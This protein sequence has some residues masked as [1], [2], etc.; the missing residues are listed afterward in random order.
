MIG[1]LS[2]A[3][4]LFSGVLLAE[5]AAAPQPAVDH[6]AGG[7]TA[8]PR[9]TADAHATGADGKSTGDSWRYKQHNGRWWYWLPANRWVVWNGAKW[10]DYNPATTSAPS[11]VQARRSYSPSTSGESKFLG[12][13]RYDRFGNPQYPYSRRRTG[14]KQLGP[15]PAMGGVRSLPGWGGER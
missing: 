1:T 8:D 9:A 2:F 5:P 13:K 7:A 3:G 4:L 6:G 10:E 14:I 11:G 12:P 15:V